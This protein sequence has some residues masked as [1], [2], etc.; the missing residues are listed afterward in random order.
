NPVA[1]LSV[2]AS[3]DG[4]HRIMWVMNPEKLSPYVTSLGA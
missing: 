4:I 2:D 3:E 1:L